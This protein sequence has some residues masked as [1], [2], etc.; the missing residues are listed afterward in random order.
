M[1]KLKTSFRGGSPFK[2]RRLEERAEERLEEA[3]ASGEVEKVEK[4]KKSEKASEDETHNVC[5]SQNKIADSDIS[6]VYGIADDEAHFVIQV[7]AHKKYTPDDVI[8]S[9]E[10]NF[11]EV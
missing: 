7:D 1:Q 5:E 10:V 2:Q 11:S 4:A 9:K 6:Q 3:A 8:E